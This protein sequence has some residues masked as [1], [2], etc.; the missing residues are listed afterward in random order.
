MPPARTA[1]GAR[2]VARRAAQQASK[3]LKAVLDGPG[4]PAPAGWGVDLGAV[5]QSLPLFRASELVAL[6]NHFGQRREVVGD[7][8]AEVA[9]EA[10][11]RICPRAAVGGAE[12]QV[13]RPEGHR[14][15]PA[16]HKDAAAVWSLSA[17]EVSFVVFSFSKITPQLPEFACV[18]EAVGRGVLAGAWNFTRLQAGLVGTAL[19]DSGCCLEDALPALLR[20]RLAEL[21]AE[22]EGAHEMV[23]DEL[24][25]L[26]HACASLPEHSRVDVHEVEALAARTRELVVSANFAKA[27]HLVV[28]WLQLEVP[29]G[30][31]RAHLEA[32][33]SCCDQ[34]HGLKPHYPAHP[35]PS[36][37]LAPAMAQLLAREKDLQGRGPPLTP[38]ALRSLTHALVE[39]SRGARWEAVRRSRSLSFDD[40]AEISQLVVGFCD[41]HRAEVAADNALRAEA[42]GG[43]PLPGWA[44]EALG[45]TFSEAFQQ[46]APGGAPPDL[47]ALL[48]ALRLLHHY[49]PFPA[50]SQA[51]FAWAAAQVT[52]HH[53]RSTAEGGGGA[54]ALAEVVGELVPRLPAADRGR[55]AALLLGARPRGRPA[56]VAL[57]LPPRASDLTA[58]TEGAERPPASPRPR[59]LAGPAAAAPEQVQASPGALGVVP[60][61]APGGHSLGAV[62]APAAAALSATSSGPGVGAR[63]G[64]GGSGLWGLLRPARPEGPGAVLAVAAAAAAEAARPPATVAIDAAAA[65]P[66]VS[67]PSEHAH[68]EVS[69]SAEAPP[70]PQA[71]AGMAAAP[72]VAVAPSEP[73]EGCSPSEID[74]LMESLTSA[75]HRVEALEARLQEREAA[76][77]AAE[78]QAA[79]AAVEAPLPAAAAAAASPSRAPVQGSRRWRVADTALADE[80]NAQAAAFRGWVPGALLQQAG[81]GAVGCERR[82]FSFDE[83]RQTNSAQ[84]QSER[85]RVLVPPDYYPIFPAAKK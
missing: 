52:E 11:R 65:R 68:A 43:R 47:G 26:V 60:A 81:P 27:A 76:G 64:G 9:A 58:A 6:A 17:R 54:A 41:A 25:Y 57:G 44:A 50:P 33:R 42:S 5:Q 15:D 49:R 8:A 73:T 62:L 74:E 3:T 48:T 18:Y 13:A 7:I 20:P 38:P 75:L 80:V 61:A 71:V 70:A 39:I 63:A 30:S 22:R 28:G 51:F 78:L 46:P 4:T 56:A 72:G 21:V 67:A 37:G 77:R 24:R 53:G 34:L 79:Q 55:L 14:L 45:H 29:L 82:A 10:G 59:L 23:V 40:W 32:L 85:L 69:L 36:G 19:A 31:K 12:P 2:L 16:A 1:Q 66:T 35:L 83:F 84:L